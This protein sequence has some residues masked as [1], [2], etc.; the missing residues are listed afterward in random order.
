MGIQR[1]RL[2]Q[3]F[4]QREETPAAPHRPERISPAGDGFTA[5]SCNIGNGLADPGLLVD[6]LARSGAS[7]VGLQE[8][9][10]AQA[11]RIDAELAGIFPHRVLH[12][13]GFAG[14]GVLSTFPLEEGAAVAFAPERPDLNATLRIGDRQLRVI[15]AHPR[16]PRISRTGMQFDPITENQV[17]MV[18][19]LAVNSRPAI[20]LCDLNTTAL[21]QAY[22]QLMAAGLID[23]FRDAGRWGATFPVR[24][25]NTHRVGQRADKWKLKP[26]LRID[27]VLHTME[28][29]ASD[30]DVGEDVGS[31]HLPVFARL[32]WQKDQ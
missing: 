23:P 5:L 10:D 29:V 16:P 28:L 30:V 32:H 12:P 31:D 2:S 1:N 19:E 24:V 11:A 8:V 15:V 6:Y 17:R 21:Q 3:L 26:V 25:G 9:S 14:K 7:I 18:G 27:Y 22:R 13:G 20:V 4:G